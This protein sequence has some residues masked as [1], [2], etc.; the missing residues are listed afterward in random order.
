M[1]EPVAHTG[2]HILLGDHDSSVNLN[3]KIHRYLR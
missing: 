3:D 1:K 2:L